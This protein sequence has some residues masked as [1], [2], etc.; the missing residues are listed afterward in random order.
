MQDLHTGSVF[1][2]AASGADKKRRKTASTP[3]TVANTLPLPA[4]TK[5]PFAELVT[6][7]Q[8]MSQNLQSAPQQFLLLLLCMTSLGDDLAEAYAADPHLGDESKTADLMSAQGLWWKGDHIVMPSSV[9]T[10]WLVL[11]V[12]YDHPMAGHSGVTKTL[13]AL[14]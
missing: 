4:F 10:K 9:D 5:Q 13:K 7:T 11:Q 3:A 6:T 14:N 12:F 2:T 1:D 8:P